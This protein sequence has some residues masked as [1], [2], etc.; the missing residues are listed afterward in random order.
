MEEKISVI[1]NKFVDLISQGTNLSYIDTVLPLCREIISVIGYDATKWPVIKI[2]DKVDI[3]GECLYYFYTV[4][5]PVNFPFELLVILMIYRPFIYHVI[6]LTKTYKELQTFNTQIFE[7]INVLYGN[8]F[9]S[10]EINYLKKIIELGSEPLENM[11]AI[12]YFHYFIGFQ[13]SKKYIS[14]TQ[15]ELDAII[16][17]RNSL[18]QINICHNYHQNEVYIYKDLGTTIGGS[19]LTTDVA[20]NFRPIIQSTIPNDY[21]KQMYTVNGEFGEKNY[22]V[23][24]YDNKYFTLLSDAEGN[25]YV[26]SKSAIERLI[27]GGLP[28]QIK[29][30]SYTVYAE[31]IYYNSL[32]KY[33]TPIEYEDEKNVIPRADTVFNTIRQVLYR[34]RT[35]EINKTIF[36][37]IIDK[38]RKSVYAI[39]DLHIDEKKL[40]VFYASCYPMENFKMNDFIRYLGEYFEPK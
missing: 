34:Y 19:F 12:T 20:K 29:L 35:E 10:E 28:N 31:T 17:N 1:R 22:C 5:N 38:I 39:N 9:S 16:P 11:S 40:F 33:I 7:E 15:Q 23:L 27:A 6:S 32:E 25:P 13:F 30:E 3:Y 24:N 21:P 37:R 8:D 26:F 2:F 4:N 18:V 14:L 36:E